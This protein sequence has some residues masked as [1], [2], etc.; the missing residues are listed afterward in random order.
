[1][2]SSSLT[3]TQNGLAAAAGWCGALADTLAAHGV[4]AGVGV[5]PLGSAAAVAGAHAQVAAAGVR[6][7]ARVQGTATK[8]TTAAAGYGANEGHAVAQ[9]RALSGPRMC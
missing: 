2:E 6:C 9:F 4:P 8:L 7:T 1:M 3:V 5:S